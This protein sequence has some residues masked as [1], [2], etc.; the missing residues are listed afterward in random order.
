[1]GAEFGGSTARLCVQ[2]RCHPMQ[3][4][5]CY[6]TA[7]GMSAINATCRCATFEALRRSTGPISLALAQGRVSDATAGRAR[8][9][10]VVRRRT[11]AS[12]RIRI[13][14]EACPRGAGASRSAWRVKPA[15][16]GTHPRMLMFV[17]IIMGLFVSDQRVT[18]CRRCPQVA[19]RQARHPAPF[20]IEL[21]YIALRERTVLAKSCPFRA[22]ELRHKY[23]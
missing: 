20:G 6:G 4:A 14:C 9:N 13:D 2:F 15:G 10:A 22:S 5:R 12:R 18:G 17:G 16:G 8:Y 7:C 19:R 21:A 23:E 1:M 3:A 11:R